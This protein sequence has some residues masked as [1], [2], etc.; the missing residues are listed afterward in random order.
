MCSVQEV[1][2]GESELMKKVLS[3]CVAVALCLLLC[4]CAKEKTVFQCVRCG[5]E[6]EVSGTAGMIT[7]SLFGGNDVLCDNCSGPATVI[8]F[9]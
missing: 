7:H 9:S 1:Q 5:V 2:R 3:V 4:G 6:I 8:T